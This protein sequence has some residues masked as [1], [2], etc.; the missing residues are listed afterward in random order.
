MTSQIQT[1]I[2]QERTMFDFTQHWGHVIDLI[3]T[4]EMTEKMRDALHA[5]SHETG[6]PEYSQTEAYPVC[7]FI[8][9]RHLRSKLYFILHRTGF[10]DWIGDGQEPESVNA[11]EIA[12]YFRQSM[13]N[14]Y[15]WIFPSKHWAMFMRELACQLVPNVDWRLWRTYY[16]LLTVTDTHNIYVFDLD[17]WL[18]MKEAI[19]PAVLT[20]GYAFDTFCQDQPSFKMHRNNE[21]KVYDEAGFFDP[22]TVFQTRLA[23]SVHSLLN[24]AA[25]RI[26]DLP[27]QEQIYASTL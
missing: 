19:H 8:D 20:P 13:D 15:W 17:E 23:P 27:I 6:I 1:F 9:V 11:D 10:F 4:P 7:L 24:I 14:P 2:M 22:S 16:K 21:S 12:E 18:R 26:A 5:I 3:Q 25:A